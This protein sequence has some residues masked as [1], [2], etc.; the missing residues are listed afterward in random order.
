MKEELNAALFDGIKQASWANVASNMQAFHTWH[1]AF[2]T[3]SNAVWD[4]NAVK[5]W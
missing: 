3:Y 4:K 5:T 2:V 1:G